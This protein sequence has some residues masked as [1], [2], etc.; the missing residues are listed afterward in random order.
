M[1][2]KLLFKFCAICM[3]GVFLLGGCSSKKEETKATSSEKNEVTEDNDKQLVKSDDEE[4]KEQVEETTDETTEETTQESAETT[5]ETIEETEETEETNE[6]W[7]VVA[8]SMVS[9]NTHIE[10]FIN[11]TSGITVGFAGEIHYTEDGG[12]SWPKS[13]NSSY[14]R[15]CLD[16]VDEQLAWSGG[17]GNHVRVSKDGGKTWSEVTD[18]NLD[19]CH[20]NIDFIND[21]TGWVCTASRCAITTDGGTTWTEITL[22][23]GMDAI[24]ATALRTSKDGYI[25]TVGGQLYI[26]A[27]AGATWSM[28][29]LDIQSYNIINL[30]LEPQLS[31]NDIAVADMTF[32]DEQNGMIVFSGIEQGKG[33]KIY[34]LRTSDGGVTWDSELVTLVDNFNPTKVFL[35][36]DGKYLTLGSIT[37]RIVVY[38]HE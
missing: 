3:I 14:C 12:A 6:A 5:D 1:K 22:P 27:D 17:N 38:K 4:T 36:S 8:D 15:F 2:K 25:L 11:E 37:K 30:D 35:T 10:G 16:I 18:I 26:T 21:T 33:T 19:G 29:D 7:K 13:E 9:H 28:Q 23:E 34:C 24:A 20:S 32:S 31:R